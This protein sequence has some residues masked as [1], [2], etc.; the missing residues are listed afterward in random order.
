MQEAL[1]DYNGQRLFFMLL[2]QKNMRS[3]I[4]AENIWLCY[5]EASKRLHKKPYI[6]Q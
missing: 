2:H 4:L 1:T 5:Y 3:E 6:K